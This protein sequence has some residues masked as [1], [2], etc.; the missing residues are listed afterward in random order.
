MLLAAARFLS[1]VARRNSTMADIEGVVYRVKK[2]GQT[3]EWVCTTAAGTGILQN[4]QN[5]LY[6]PGT[7]ITGGHPP[8]HAC[9]PAANGPFHGFAALPVCVLC[10]ER[11]GCG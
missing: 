8:H 6:E 7:N 2:K 1:M 11:Q 4:W 3:V 9:G 10:R 5:H